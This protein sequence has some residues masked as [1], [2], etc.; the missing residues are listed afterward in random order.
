MAIKEILQGKKIQSNLTPIARMGAPV[1]SWQSRA[2]DMMQEP[3]NSLGLLGSK[4][5]W[6][7][8]LAS[9]V[10]SGLG[11]YGAMK[12]MENQKA[13]NENLAQMAEQERQDKLAQQ[14]WEQEYK[15]RAL[16]QDLEKAQ[17]SIAADNRRAEIARGY[18]LEDAERRRLQEVA[19]A[20]LK[21]KQAL[22]DREAQ[23]QHELS[24]YNR[25]RENQL[26]DA[27]DAENRK[28]AYEQEQMAIKQ[29][30]PASQQKYYQMK[31]E[32]QTPEIID[33][34]VG[35]VGKFFGRPK[36]KLS[37]ADV[38]KKGKG[39]SATE[40]DIMSRGLK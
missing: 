39:Y 21:R 7:S 20:E 11:F 40:A 28:Q 8:G 2:A 13:Y 38:V 33:K 9:A 27:L 29:L 34:K 6:V 36:Y 23:Y 26:Q 1:R 35:L 24:V 22:E 12:D 4:G 25:N 31:Q 19:D 3:D 18:A 30:D 37:V 32:G 10:K 16:A 15:K 5:N 17:L 14:A